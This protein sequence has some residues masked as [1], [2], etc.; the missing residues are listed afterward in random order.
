MMAVT[1]F[2]ILIA[3]KSQVLSA[4]FTINGSANVI[5]LKSF[6]AYYN[7]NNYAYVVR[8]QDIQ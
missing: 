6:N 2:C 1:I 5:S 7:I 4:K 3:R 8:S